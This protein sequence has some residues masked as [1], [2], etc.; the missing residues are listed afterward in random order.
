MNDFHGI[1]T[2][3]RDT[4]IEGS[5]IIAAVHWFNIIHDHKAGVDIQW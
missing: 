3:F 4:S 1:N 5:D 2:V